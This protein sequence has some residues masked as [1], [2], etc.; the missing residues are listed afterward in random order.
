MSEKSTN[1][2]RGRLKST[3]DTS[4]GFVKRQM[5]ALTVN[6]KEHL[7]TFGDDVEPWEPGA[8]DVYPTHTLIHT[9]REKLPLNGT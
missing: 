3:A 2:R 7:L 1:R 9:L 4:M 8:Y 6:G 5:I